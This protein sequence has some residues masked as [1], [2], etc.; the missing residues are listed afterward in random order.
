MD[1][2]STIHDLPFLSETA[3]RNILGGNAMR[4]FNLEPVLSETKRARLAAGATPQQPEV[5]KVFDI[6]SSPQA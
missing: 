6:A 3:K 4:L 1:L 5:K 2:P